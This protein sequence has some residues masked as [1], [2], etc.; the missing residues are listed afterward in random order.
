MR[1]S[2]LVF[3]PAPPSRTG[4]L[5][6]AANSMPRVKLLEDPRPLYDGRLIVACSEWV[7]VTTALLTAY[8]TRLSTEFQQCT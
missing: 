2:Q 6:T 8:F 5:Q 3:F 1:S 4:P 7:P